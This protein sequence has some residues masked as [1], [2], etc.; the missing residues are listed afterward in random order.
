MKYLMRFNETIADDIN[1]LCDDYLSFLKDNGFT[2]N[3][4]NFNK[5]TKYLSIYK[6]YDEWK[7]VRFN[8]SEV[9]DDFIPF[10]ELLHN[11]YKIAFNTVSFSGYEPI[12]KLS[13]YNK[14]F[15][16]GEILNGEVPYNASCESID[17]QIT[18][19]I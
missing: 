16:I 18:V 15:S 4:D 14:L 11:K 3:V 19:E 10:L 7:K 2:C 8:W 13:Q 6:G 5:Y 1:K 12:R 9:S 17:I